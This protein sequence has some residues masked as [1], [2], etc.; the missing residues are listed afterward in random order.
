MRSIQNMHIN[1]N[2]WSD[3]GYNFLVGGDG[4]IYEGRGWGK[5]GAHAPGYNDKSVGIS[6]IGTFTS[7]LPTNA[8][9]AAGKQLINCGVSLGHVSRTYSL[10]GHRQAT[11]TECPGNKLYEEIKTWPNYKP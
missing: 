6:F 11:S 8:A 1:T 4:L 9:L 2:G 7:G 10:I 3:I 5:Q